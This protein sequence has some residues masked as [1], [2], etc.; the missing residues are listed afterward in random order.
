VIAY[1]NERS[2]HFE[3]FLVLDLDIQVEDAEK[4]REHSRC[5]STRSMI[6]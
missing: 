3:V 6:Y 4:E 1:D 2:V 5:D